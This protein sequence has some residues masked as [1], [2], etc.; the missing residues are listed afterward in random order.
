MRKVA[1]GIIVSLVVMGAY[2][3]VTRATALEWTSQSDWAFIFIS[4][5]AGSGVTFK[6][7]RGNALP[8]ACTF[9]FSLPVLLYFSLFYVCGVHGQCL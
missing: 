4:A 9:V 6:V 8:A 1:T 3:T 2:I 5:T 7:L